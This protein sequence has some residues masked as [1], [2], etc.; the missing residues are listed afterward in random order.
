[1]WLQWLQVQVL[2]QVQHRRRCRHWRED[3][4]IKWNS[5]TT[6]FTN[7]K[8][9]GKETFN[10]LEQNDEL[11]TDNLPPKEIEQTIK[12]FKTQE[13]V[14]KYYTDE[15]KNKLGGTGRGPNKNKPNKY[16][17]YEATIKKVTKVWSVIELKDKPYIG[18]NN[19]QWRFYPCYEDI[20]D[21][22]T[23]QWWF[24]HD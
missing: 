13:E 19:N 9:S 10:N 12:K 14:K 1:M 8:I 7:G 5:K 24:I 15:L 11:S 3:K 17:Y 20:N 23:L 16:G 4:T 22:S 6:Q 2:L 21:K 18:S